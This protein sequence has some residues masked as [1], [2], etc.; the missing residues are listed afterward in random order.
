[1]LRG[2]SE[3]KER[4]Y[5]LR[6]RMSQ[7][8]RD[9]W[10][11]QRGREGGKTAA[12]RRIFLHK[13]P[14]TIDFNHSLTE[15]AL[16]SACPAFKFSR[17]PQSSAAAA[18]TE[19]VCK[20]DVKGIC[21]FQLPKRPPPPFFFSRTEKAASLCAYLSE[22]WRLSSCEE[23][24]FSRAIGNYSHWVWISCQIPNR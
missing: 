7:K 8:R 14:E 18:H 15:L 13:Q 22:C 12:G 11:E 24:T 1:M 19:P 16:P 4:N 9:L 3:G 20:S 2:L 23:I 21:N 6:P 17:V 10:G 5:F